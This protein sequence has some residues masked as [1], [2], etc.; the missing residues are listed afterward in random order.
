MRIAT[1]GHLRKLKQLSSASSSLNFWVE[2]FEFVAGVV[3]FEL[4][5][6]AALLSVRLLRPR[7]DFLSQFCQIANP[8]SS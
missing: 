1:S 5:V 8:T 3:D 6:D 2:A 7:G 4:P